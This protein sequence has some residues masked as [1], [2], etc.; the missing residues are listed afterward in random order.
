LIVS[1]RHDKQMLVFMNPLIDSAIK[2]PANET[3]ILQAANYQFLPCPMRM[4]II[5]H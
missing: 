2:L 5:I 1:S 4:T 3:W